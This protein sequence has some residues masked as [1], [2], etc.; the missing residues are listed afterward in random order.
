MVCSSN[1]IFTT[2]NFAFDWYFN[3]IIGFGKY[4]LEAYIRPKVERN[5]SKYTKISKPDRDYPGHHRACHW[6]IRVQGV[7]I[8]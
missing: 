1:I 3:K 6:K 7:S 8:E 4:W 5:G 2:K